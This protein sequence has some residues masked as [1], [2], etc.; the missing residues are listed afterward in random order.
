MLPKDLVI[1]QQRQLNELLVL[2]V[3]DILLMANMH[4]HTAKQ[5]FNMELE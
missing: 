2:K 1:M 3:G 5:C 4:A